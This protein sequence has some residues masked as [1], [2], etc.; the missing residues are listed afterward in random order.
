MMRIILR[1]GRVAEFRE[2][3]SSQRDRA[4][5]RELF[6]HVSAESLYYRF[7]QVVGELSDAF[8]DRQL[9]VNDDNNQTLLCMAGEHAVD[10]GSYSRVDEERAEVAFLVDDCMQGKGIGTMLLEH[11]AETAWRH[12]FKRFDAHVLTGN[13]RMIEVFKSSGYELQSTLRSDEIHLTLPLA[14]TERSRAF[15]DIREKLATAASLAP[16]FRPQSVAVISAIHDPTHLGHAIFR[17]ILDGGFCGTVHCVNENGQALDGAPAYSGVSDIAGPIDLAVVAVSANDALRVADDCIRAGVRAVVVTSGGFSERDWEGVQSEQ[18][19]TLRLR[20]AGSRLIGP[21]CM[22]LVNTAPDVRLN[23][24][25]ATHLPCRGNVAIASQSGALGI[26]MLEH[27]SRIGLGVSSFASM[28]N[29]ADVSGND[30]L[31][32]WED[33]PDTGMIL[34]Y[35]ESFGNPR[36]FSR[37]ARRITQKKPIVAVKSARTLTG[38]TVSEAR[39]T[40]LPTS[41]AMVDGLFRRT[42]IIRVDTLQVL[43]DVAALL[44]LESLSLGRRIAIL[45][46]TAGGAV[47]T[48]DALLQE[49][50]LLVRSPM[51]LGFEALADDY[52]QA[53]PELLR[54]PSV[55]AVMVIFIS[56]GISAGEEVSHAIAETL[57]QVDAQP[58]GTESEAGKG[59][60]MPTQ[61]PHPIKPVI[62]NFMSTG[63][64]SVWFIEAGRR[65]VPVYPFPERAV[66]ALAKVMDY[67]E[68]CCA[69]RGHIPDLERVD[70][71]MARALA[72]QAMP[73][74]TGWLPHDVAAAILGAL[75]IRIDSR[76]SPVD[77][78]SI[79]RIC[80]AIEWDP[81]FGMVI[82]LRRE[83]DRNPEETAA[84]CRI[85]DSDVICTTPLT[86]RDCKDMVGG[87]LRED[88]VLSASSAA[89]DLEELLQRLSRLVEEVYEISGVVLSNIEVS[90]SGYWIKNHAMAAGTRQ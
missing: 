31:Q 17:H 13:Y 70:C 63:N 58:P 45:T 71:D 3:R 42:G 34:L 74:V 78:K 40:A 56:S 67:A 50:L 16:F 55:D 77:E 30:L 83:R 79:L 5:I 20:A 81:L 33:D 22:G 57:R 61:E 11:L 7:F 85:S 66:R 90:E 37:I 88:P 26:T 39:L 4:V 69:P 28:G 49:G 68:Y 15:H 9:K 36:K 52:R 32:Y 10:M 76:R 48:V 51:D 54:D 60:D 24:S 19:I 47:M 1:D 29:K 18:A 53:L 59:V 62:A 72:R 25:P 82:G 6:A 41:D 38:A 65:R 2:M 27:A 8:I 21:N 23:A 84:S 44:S 73:S 12:G 64:E 87:V 89:G 80:A 43:F 35:L 14:Q 75:G 46:N 86:D